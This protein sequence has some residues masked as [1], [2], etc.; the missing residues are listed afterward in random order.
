MEAVANQTDPRPTSPAGRS[1]W[2]LAGA[3]GLLLVIG[4]VTALWMSRSHTTSYPAGSAPGTVQRYLRLLQNHQVSQAYAMI[5]TDESLQAFHME[6]DNWGN[7][8]HQATLVGSRVSGDQATVAVEIS[9]F[10][11][12]P[13]ETSNSSQRVTFTLTRQGKGWVIDDPPYLPY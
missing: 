8:S 6:Y 4:V 9:S 11:A 12:G 13:L 3:V 2:V 5:I 7:T 1:I 10:D